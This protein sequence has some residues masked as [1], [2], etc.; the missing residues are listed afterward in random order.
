MKLIYEEP[1]INIRKYDF[2]SDS[3]F[4]SPSEPN[5]GDGDDFGDLDVFG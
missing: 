1:E 5:L 3:L 4:T 2:P